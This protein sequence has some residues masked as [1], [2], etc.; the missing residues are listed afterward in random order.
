MSPLATSHQFGRFFTFSSMVNHTVAVIKV[1]IKN[2]A[3]RIHEA[4]L[5]AFW[6]FFVMKNFTVYITTKTVSKNTSIAKSMVTICCINAL[7]SF[8]LIHSVLKKLTSFTSFALSTTKV[9]KLQPS[10]KNKNATIPINFSMVLND[11]C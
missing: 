4:T 5:F 10:T 1:M 8:G 6:F 11:A 2:R 9:I 3:A 7:I